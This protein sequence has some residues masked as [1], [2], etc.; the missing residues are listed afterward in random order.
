MKENM[1]KSGAFP[2]FMIAAAVALLCAPLLFATRGTAQNPT[3]AGAAGPAQ[4]ETLPDWSNPEFA[5]FVY[6]VVSIK[7]FK[8]DDNSGTTLGSQ[9]MPDGF[10][11][12]FPLQGLI[13]EAFKTD[14]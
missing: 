5:K 9:W 7:P 11:A 14:H 4:T 10:T 12:A 8:T 6:S 2:C 3:Q 13:Y 1:K